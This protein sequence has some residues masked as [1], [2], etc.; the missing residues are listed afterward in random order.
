MIKD[1]SDSFKAYLYDRTTSPLF[2]AFAV[3]WCV[4]NYEMILT[5][6][7][8][9]S[10]DRKIYFIQSTLYPCDPWSPWWLNYL[11]HSLDLFFYPFVSAVAVLLLYP[12]PSKWV[13]IKWKSHQIQMHDKKLE[14]EKTKLVSTEIH[15]KLRSEYFEMKAKFQSELRAKDEEIESL[16][17]SINKLK[18]DEV[19]TSSDDEA[20]E[21][22]ILQKDD[23]RAAEVNDNFNQNYEFKEEDLKLIFKTLAEEGDYIEANRLKEMLRSRAGIGKTKTQYCL[24]QLER[25]G[26]IPSANNQYISL[27]PKGRKIAV[28]QEIIE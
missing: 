24:D 2:A 27:T 20:D 14:L 18:K 19:D 5:I 25:D 16:Q 22:R 17:E 12:I 8:D 1:F 3:S 7:S 21:S 15:E 9:W 4:W 28:E 26:L 6:F 10:V 11:S 13:Y 23:Q